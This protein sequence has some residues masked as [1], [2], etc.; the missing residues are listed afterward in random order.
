MLYKS[1]AGVLLVFLIVLTGNNSLKSQSVDPPFLKY[2]NHPWV[3]S[4]M[5]TLTVDKRIAQCIWIA[6]YS[7]RDVSHEVEISDIIRKFGVGGIIFF[8]G[9]P[10]K[11]AELTTF[12][13]KI[14]GVPLLI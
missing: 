4:V 8:Q 12:Y 14:S 2:M 3:D 9:T 1:R 6:A 10:G 5:N 11:Q 13:Q 7:N